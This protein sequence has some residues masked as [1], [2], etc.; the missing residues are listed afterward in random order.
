MARWEKGK[1]N[2]S[3]CWE[4]MQGTT[5]GGGGLGVG[6]MLACPA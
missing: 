2:G 3:P 5:A 4:K 1:A 6:E